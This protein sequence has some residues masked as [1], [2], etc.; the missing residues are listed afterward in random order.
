MRSYSDN[1]TALLNT[2]GI[3]DVELYYDYD[4]EE[5]IIRGESVVSD[6]MIL[7]ESCVT[8]TSI[9]IGTANASEFK[10][11]LVRDDNVDSIE[12]YDKEFLVN[13]RVGTGIN[14]HVN[15]GDYIVTDVEYDE[16]YIHLTM[17]DEMIKLDKPVDW[18]Q[19]ESGVVTR[20][21]RWYTSYNIPTSVQTV[22][23]LGFSWEENI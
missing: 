2:N 15:L 17:L 6:S 8:G 1:L 12:F 18:S 13:L 21:K 19:L 7:D 4:G 23:E 5:I 10:V 3:I 11:Q 22:A 16:N 9:E 14:D 20:A